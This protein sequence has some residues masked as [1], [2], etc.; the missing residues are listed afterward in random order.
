MYFNVLVKNNFVP[1]ISYSIRA[2]GLLEGV[3]QGITAVLPSQTEN[4][5]ILIVPSEGA[6]AAKSTKKKIT[7]DC[8][9]LFIPLKPKAKH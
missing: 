2:A 9:N 4:L 1:F 8:N 7:I 5:D 6:K 3:E